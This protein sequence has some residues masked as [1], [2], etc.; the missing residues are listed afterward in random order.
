TERSFTPHTHGD[1]TLGLL[2]MLKTFQLRQREL[3]LTIYGPPGL[4]DLFGGLRP[5]FGKLSYPLELVEVRSGEALD[6]D[7]YR[8]LVFP[9]HHG[10]SAVGYALDEHDRPGRFDND[11]ADTLGIPIGPE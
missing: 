3:P 11:T 5:V 8:I 9:V 6:R 4:R 1:H 10:V 2:E 7:G